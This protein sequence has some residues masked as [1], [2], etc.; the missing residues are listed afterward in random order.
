MALTA[1]LVQ[2]IER[3][4]IY[5]HV[6]A[7]ICSLVCFTVLFICS[8]QYLRTKRQGWDNMAAACGEV[9]LIFA[10]VLNL[11]GSIFARAQ[12]GL[13]WT[14]SPR[15][16]SSA[17]LWFLYVA[18]LLLRTALPAERRRAAIC[19]VF[20]IIAFTDVPLVLISARFVRDIHRPSF[21]FQSAAQ[22]SAFILA[23]CGTLVLAVL[24]IWLRTD[25]L[26]IKGRE[27]NL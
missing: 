17:V 23:V 15:L 20:G 19:A 16:I 8:I 6:P 24:L 11:T 4:I 10:T 18:Y 25:I 27:T 21:S 14:A 12:W 5:L 3:N 1:G 7:A 13:W 9:G 22:T 26:K 2:P